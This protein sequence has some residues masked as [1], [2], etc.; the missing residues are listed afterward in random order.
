MGA[1]RRRHNRSARSPKRRDRLEGVTR[2]RPS[3]GPALAGAVDLSGPQAA[4]ARAMPARPRAVP[5]GGVEITEANFEAEVLVR[6]NEVP[7]VVLL[8][9]PRSEASIQLGDALAAPGGLPTAASG[10]W[11][12]STST[13]R[14]G[15]RR[16]SACRR[17]R[18]WWRWLPASRSRASR[19]ASRP[20]SC[21][22][23]STRCCPPPRASWPVAP[24]GE[25]EEVDPELA[26]AREHL[27]AG[28]F[29]AARDRLSG[30]PRRRPEP[31]RGQGRDA[32]DRLPAAGD[33]RS[34]PTRSHAPTPHPTTSRRRSPPPTSRSSAGR[35]GGIRP[36]DRVGEAHRRRRAHQGADP[37]DR[38]V[39]AVRPRRPRG[40]RRPA[41]PR[42]RAVLITASR[43][44]RNGAAGRQAGSNHSAA[45]GGSTITADAG[46]PCHGSSVASTAPK[47]P[48]PEPL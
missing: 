27:D 36:A 17:C 32:S 34:R 35:H 22:A 45:S 47:L 6:S 1:P 20:S 33:G 39:R 5:P 8:W 44:S 42:Q 19:A 46:R 14:R 9:S 3:I 11:R 23:G 40:H 43:R 21:G 18:P 13:P 31:R 15:W 2:P 48:M 28:D 16:C 4:T 30:D 37:A 41:Q 12:R 26:Q 29:D 7:V 25:A 38:A 24:E 10:R